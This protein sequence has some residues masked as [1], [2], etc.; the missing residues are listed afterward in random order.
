MPS[1][2]RRVWNALLNAFGDGEN[3]IL[4]RTGVINVKVLLGDDNRVPNLARFSGQRVEE[5]LNV[6]WAQYEEYF[7]D[8]RDLEQEYYGAETSEKI[9]EWR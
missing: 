4:S 5:L 6:I 2:F 8:A 3:S 7:E 1:D 9:D